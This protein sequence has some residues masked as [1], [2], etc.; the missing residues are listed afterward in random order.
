MSLFLLTRSFHLH[1]LSLFCF[2]AALFSVLF[3][4]QIS[5]DDLFHLLIFALASKTLL[6]YTIIFFQKPSCKFKAFSLVNPNCFFFCLLF[7]FHEKEKWVVGTN[8]LEP[9]TSRLSGVRSNHLS[10]AP[11]WWRWG[12]SNS[13]PPACK[14]GALPAEL[15]PHVRVSLGFSSFFL[16]TLFL[17]EYPQ[18]WTMLSFYLL[19]L[20]DRSFWTFVRAP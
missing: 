13:W 14:A 16:Q 15:H 18:N 17:L 9:S 11:F 7:F 2:Q 6:S 20:A 3:Q 4:E 5:T 8:G 10:Y 1:L 19:S 12:G